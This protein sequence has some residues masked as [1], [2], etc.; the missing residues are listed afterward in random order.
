MPS[1][2]VLVVPTGSANLAS[3]LAGLR[4]VGA[5]PRPIERPDEILSAEH[6]VLPGVGSFAAAIE[7]LKARSFYEPLR[8]RAL[9]GR[10]L[11]AICLG[12][13]ILCDSSEEDA[14][15]GG[16]GVIPSA[17]RA[18]SGTLRVP[19]MGWNRIAPDSGCRLLRP[20]FAYFAN[21]YRLERAPAGWSAA[22][23]DHGGKYVAALERDGVLACQFHPELSGAWGVSLLDRWLSGPA[24]GSR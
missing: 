19:Q 16:L 18:Y 8:E 2:R 13:Q 21:S 5:I 9:L 1:P 3:V 11:L 14:R 7:H 24:I 6:V 15:V 23:S 17:V 20:G 22:F 12:M 4:R 10:S